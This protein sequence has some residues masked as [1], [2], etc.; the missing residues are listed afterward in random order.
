MAP[1]CAR[2]QR[3]LRCIDEGRRFA[4][5]ARRTMRCFKAKEFP[6]AMVHATPGDIVEVKPLGTALR[7]ILSHAL[8]KSDQ[9]EIIRLVLRTGDE[10]PSHA[11]IGE[12]TLQ[13]IEGRV[14]LVCNAGE[15]QLGAGQ[16]VH[17]GGGE[18]HA[19]RSLEDASLLMT[20]VLK[21]AAG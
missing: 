9:L 15:R 21:P 1:R 2:Q 6:M 16:L 4:H 18:Q 7:S 19:L 11:V 13:C 10:I 5:D 8:F 17:L 12:S 3:D 20:I 14:A